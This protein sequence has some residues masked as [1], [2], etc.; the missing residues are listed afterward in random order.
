LLYIKN[1]YY[2][3]WWWKKEEK[4]EEKKGEG[5]TR[6]VLLFDTFAASTKAHGPYTLTVC[7]V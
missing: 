5:A 3:K 2:K 4:K 7:T 1:N 6:R